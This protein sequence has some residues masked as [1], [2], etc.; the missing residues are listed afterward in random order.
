MLNANVFFFTKGKPTKEV[1]TYDLRT[2]I[3]T[4]EKGNPLT[5]E[6]FEDLIKCYSQKTRKQTERFQKR[7][8]KQIQEN[9][10]NDLDFKFIKDE[11][12]LDLDDLPEPKYY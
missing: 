9:N 11:N 4:L 7:T 3:Q 12:L 1:W 2:N 5:E 6:L 10:F 8:I